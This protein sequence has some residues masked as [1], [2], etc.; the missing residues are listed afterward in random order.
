[1]LVATAVMVGTPGQPVVYV[2]HSVGMWQGSHVAH[3]P[4]DTVVVGVVG[5]QSVEH[6]T[7]VLDTL[8]YN[9]HTWSVAGGGQESVGQEA[10]GAVTVWVWH[11]WIPVHAVQCAVSTYVVVQV[12]GGGV[13]TGF[14]VVGAGL[15]LRASATAGTAL[16]V[17]SS[18]AV[19]VRKTMYGENIMLR[20]CLGR[21]VGWS[22]GRWI[23]LCM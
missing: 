16:T 10:A 3:G 17:A 1:M 22:M 2:I 21:S 20:R 8:M 4:L 11:T 14:S 23:R 19:A 18:P 6:G 9:G 13:T 5:Q 15:G 12:A 7:V